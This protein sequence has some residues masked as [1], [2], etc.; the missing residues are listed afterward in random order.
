M[1]R[2]L[3]FHGNNAD[4]NSAGNVLKLFGGGG[5]IGSTLDSCP[6][7]LGSSPGLHIFTVI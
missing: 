5:V 6:K 7:D 3:P 1:V 4:S 2:T